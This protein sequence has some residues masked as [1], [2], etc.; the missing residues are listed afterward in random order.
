MEKEN[1]R[2]IITKKLLKEGLLKLLKKKNVDKITVTELCEEAGINRATFYRH[3]SVPVDV[4]IDI[5]EDLT[6]GAE[7]YLLPIS[8]SGHGEMILSL[9]RFIYENSGIIKTLIKNKSD[10][11]LTKLI[12]QFYHT[13][14]E[15]RSR[16]KEL[17]GYDVESLKLIS[18]YFAGG[19]YY[20]LKAWI[21]EGVKK[22][23]EEM[24]ALIMRFI[25]RLI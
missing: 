12:K 1:Q 20:M 5:E 2:I 18:A 11:Y 19:A 21:T 10:E 17:D 13:L 16:A 23:P 22:T 14:L 3:Y 7:M 15:F 25:D 24:A 4:L 6:K 9:C 8:E